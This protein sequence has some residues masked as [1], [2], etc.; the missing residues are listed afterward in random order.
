MVWQLSRT[1]AAL[2]LAALAAAAAS[3]VRAGGTSLNDVLRRAGAYVRQFEKDFS[4]I[5][6]DEQY[7]QN[8][9]RD[10]LHEHRSLR[11]EMLFMRLPGQGLSWLTA[12]NVLDVDGRAVPDSHDRLERAIKGTS[13]ALVERLHSV[14]DEGARFNLGNVFR[15]F[16]DPNLALLF[17][18]PDYQR[19]FRFHLGDEEDVSGV[20][21][22]RVS[23]KETESP[24]VIRQLTRKN[25]FTSGAAW[26][27]VEDGVVMRT[28]L[29]ATADGRLE[30]SL[31]VDYQ[32]D[33]KLEMWIPAR[34][35][36]RYVKRREREEIACTATY[37]NPRR[38]ETSG[39]V[40]AK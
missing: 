7:E 2:A 38:F 21:A 16:N 5:I 24:T 11:S 23:F 15:N 30:V 34:M 13:G 26:I 39:R 40:I 18:D 1:A 27:H 8:Y 20:R 36:E 14:A 4:A 10:T 17:F 9:S 19:R 3:P 25:L 31:R 33:P 29:S 22:R 32:R 28:E 12:R 35:V 6:T 37:S